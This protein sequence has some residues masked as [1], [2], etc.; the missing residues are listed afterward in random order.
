LLC[1]SLYSPALSNAGS[2]PIKIP[3]IYFDFLCEWPRNCLNT[4]RCQLAMHHI[5]EAKSEGKFR[6]EKTGEQKIAGDGSE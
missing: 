5:A 3:L 2:M 4:V 6:N 1:A